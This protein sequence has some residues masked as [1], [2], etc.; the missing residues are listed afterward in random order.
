MY[1][2]QRIGL[3]SRRKGDGETVAGTAVTVC[4]AVKATNIGSVEVQAGINLSFQ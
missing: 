3:R 1:S 4:L 2:A